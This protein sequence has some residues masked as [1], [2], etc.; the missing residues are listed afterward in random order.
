MS[1]QSEKKPSKQKKKKYP[2]PLIRWTPNLP[3]VK[4]DNIISSTAREKNNFGFMPTYEVHNHPINMYYLM[5]GEYQRIWLTERDAFAK[6]VYSAPARLFDTSDNNFRRKFVQRLF[7]YRKPTKFSCLEARRRDWKRLS[8]DEAFAIRMR[9]TRF[10]VPKECNLE[11]EKEE[12]CKCTCDENK[13][14]E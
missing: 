11:P 3:I 5:T 7:T 6:A 10:K 9:E 14:K 1:E 13:S 2:V 12:K 4:D 8:A